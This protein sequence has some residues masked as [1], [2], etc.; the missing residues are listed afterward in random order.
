MMDSRL[1]RQASERLISSRAQLLKYRGLVGFDGFVTTAFEVVEQRQSATRYMTYRSRKDFSGKIAAAADKNMNFEIIPNSGK[2]SGDGS[3][4]AFALGTLGVS[5]EYVGMAGYPK[6]HPAF[7]ELA[8]RTKVHGLANP[9]LISALEFPADR[10]T[11]GQLATAREVSWENIKKRLGEKNFAKLWQQSDFVMMTNWTKLPHLS[12]LWKR[13]LGEF[14]PV[15]GGKRKLL[16]F[17][18]GDLTGRID[19]DLVAAVKIIG[20]FRQNHDV[21]LGLNESEARRVAKVL[22]LNQFPATPKGCLATASVIR[23]KLGLHTVVIHPMQYACGADREGEISVTGPYTA[24]PKTVTG[25]GNIFNTAFLI[26]RLLGLSLAHSLQLAVA[27]SG[28][29]V[30]HAQGPNREQLMRF[31]QTL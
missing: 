1:A 15:R 9:G 21:I 25:A 24:K 28:Y 30:R 26:G 29:Y 13:I 19:T 10:L 3:I 17:D 6:L 7:S 14:K 11:L 12:D 2:I 5:V 22:R 16:F 8:K 18:L 4:A 20:E 31:L 23:E 27:G